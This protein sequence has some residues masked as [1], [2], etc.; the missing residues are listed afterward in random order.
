MGGAMSR[1]YARPRAGIAKIFRYG[2]QI[3]RDAHPTKISTV[4]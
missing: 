4:N 3:I 2:E 1:E